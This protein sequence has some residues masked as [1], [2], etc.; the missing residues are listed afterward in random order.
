MR[1]WRC[2]ECLKRFY[3]PVN[4]DE[5]MLR[6]HEWLRD[7]EKPSESQVKRKVLEKDHTG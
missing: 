1:P 5:K 4:L 7:N 6:E 2:R 3:L